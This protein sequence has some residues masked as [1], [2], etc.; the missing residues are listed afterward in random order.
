[1]RPQKLLD[2]SDSVPK[3][4]I[5]EIDEGMVPVRSLSIK[6]NSVRVRAWFSPME[7]ESEP[8]SLFRE[9]SITPSD[10]DLKGGNGPLRSF[11]ATSNVWRLGKAATSGGMVP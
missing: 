9:A 4:F 8:D 2:P 6:S 1:M 11:S 10:I 3:F 7:L 5:L